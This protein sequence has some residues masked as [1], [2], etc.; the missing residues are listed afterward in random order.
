M[1]PRKILFDA[2]PIANPRPSGVGYYTQGLVQALAA[3]GGDSLE[4]VGHYFAA[5]SSTKRLPQ[6]PNIRYTPSRLWHPKI[7][8]QLRR[9]GIDIPIEILAR[10]KADFIIYPAFFGPPSL[11]GTPMTSMIHDVTYLDHPEMVAKRNQQDL[12]RFVP[13]TIGRSAFTVTISQFSKGK[14]EEA[15]PKLLHETLITPVPPAPW[16]PAHSP[17]KTL[18]KFGITKDY[19]LFIGNLEPRKNLGNLALAYSKLPN[20]LKQRFS[21]VLAGAEGWNNLD[22]MNQIRALIKDG[23]DIILTGYV[24]DDERN[25]LFA[26]ATALCFPST[27]EGFG[28]PILEAMQAKIPTAISD[29]PVFHEVAGEAA[30][31]FD[32]TKPTAIAKALQR[33]LQDTS[34]R[35]QLIKQGNRQVS[36]YNWEQVAQSVL[37]KI[38]SVLG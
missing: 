32:P 36:T 1:R 19:V 15:Y 6:A 20:A 11:F 26:Q 13:K 7:V 38:D 8:N 2:N 18:K 9:Q 4:L 5:G 25:A 30:L 12:A 27:Y 23:N 10:T 17:Q 21:L 37:S 29:M 34:L 24:N 14:L 22:D 35:Q 3:A 16:Q 33:L 31:Y 28:M